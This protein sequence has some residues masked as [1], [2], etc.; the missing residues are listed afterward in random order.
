VNYRYSRNYFPPAPVIDIALITAAESLRV[1]PLSALIDS[2]AD[3]T[4]IPI[5][6]LNEIHAPPTEEMVIRSQWGESQ[7]V[8]MYLV[9]VQI[10]G[11]TLPGIEVV[12]D[13][14]SDEIIVGRDILNHLRVLLDGPSEKVEVSE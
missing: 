5:N 14:I 12:G 6:Y 1:G 2:G 3:G 4:I 7:S 13:E 10:G 8:M 9:D 11:L